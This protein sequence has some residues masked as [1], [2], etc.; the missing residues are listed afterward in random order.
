MQHSIVH[1]KT[2]KED[3]TSL[4]VDAEYFQIQPLVE[5]LNKLDPQSLEQL[6]SWITQG[7]NPKFTDVGIPCLTGRNI[8]NEEVTF[9]GAD[10][11]DK[12]EYYSLRKFQLI[13]G[14]VLITLKGSG[15][16]GKVALFR[17]N[18]K[19]IFSRNVGLI[20]LGT[21]KITPEL[22]FALLASDLGQEIIDRGVTGG[23]GQL[24]L[25]TSYLKN[26]N[27]PT[28]GNSFVEKVTTL[29]TEVHQLAD[30]SKSL[31]TQAEELLLSELGLADW[32][33]THE[34]SFVKNYSDTQEAK[35][36]DAEYFQPKYEEIIKAVKE[37]EGG[38]D[39]L[40][41]LVTTKKCIEPGSSAYQ[42]GG[43]PFVRVSNLSK[44]EI[45][46]NNQQFISEELY[47]D[48]KAHQPKQNE[49][50]L[51]KDAT[52][53]IAYYLKNKPKKMIPSGGILRLKVKSTKI[54]PEYLTLVLNSTVVQKQIEQDA[55]GSVINH[56]R[57]DQVKSTIIPI[58]ESNKQEQIKAFVEKSFEDRHLS[59]S[60]LEIAKHG[61][62]LAIEKDEHTAE[63][64]INSEIDSI[65]ITL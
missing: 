17:D 37:Y 9:E 42:E 52:P 56:W 25:P 58:L 23:T 43:I 3:S 18:S 8:T 65:G 47:K 29:V 14:D 48:L 64:W 10:Q 6:S 11:I 40:G 22:L 28:F 35:R 20:R 41:N 59:K 21:Q 44:F 54:L 31:Y 62:E 24:T 30:S 51:S 34:R 15:S 33:P 38:W 32:Q 19:A 50:L 13:T 45:T 60:L 4:R 39:E 5:R 36:V 57:P 63:T 49:I 7:P 46:T 27:V 16:T 1:Y 53:G 55:G 61:V 26:V 12:N 2:V